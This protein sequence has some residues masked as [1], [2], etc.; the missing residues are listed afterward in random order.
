MRRL[1]T[2]LHLRDTFKI[3]GQ[4]FGFGVMNESSNWDD[5]SYIGDDVK[6]F[7]KII[8]ELWTFTNSTFFENITLTLYR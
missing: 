3:F 7:L 5:Y 6:V 8:G 4:D 2:V 1:G